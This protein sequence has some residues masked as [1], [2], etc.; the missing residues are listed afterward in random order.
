MADEDDEQS[1]SEK[2]QK[3][4]TLLPTEEADLVL[5]CQNSNN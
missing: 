1:R 2:N 4:L 3:P 5:F